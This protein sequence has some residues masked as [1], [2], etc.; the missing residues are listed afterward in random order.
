M[1]AGTGMLYER[2][3]WSWCD[4]YK[5]VIKAENKS[6]IMRKINNW[7]ISIPLPDRWY[8]CYHNTHERKAQSFA[9]FGSCRMVF[10]VTVHSQL[11]TAR[12]LQSCCH[13]QT[14]CNKVLSWFYEAAEL[15]RR[16]RLRQTTNLLGSFHSP[17]DLYASHVSGR[18]HPLSAHRKVLAIHF[19]KNSR[20][21]LLTASNAQAK[22]L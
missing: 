8:C 17:R 4:M 20:I 3:W 19:L 21:K 2:I 5:M 14:G 18:K 13:S 1:T 7:I 16:K 22:V 11:C 15:L 6:L 9:C 12:I 10:G